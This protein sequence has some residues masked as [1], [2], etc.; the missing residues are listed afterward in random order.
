VQ[1]VSHLGFAAGVGKIV[2]GAMLAASAVATSVPTD[3]G[4]A[5]SAQPATWPIAPA[6]V[7]RP[8]DAPAST[9]G[10]GHRGVDLAAGVGQPVVSSMA[11]IVTV[12]GKVAGRPVVVVKHEGGIRTT[13]LP[14]NP[15]VTVGEHVG[16]GQ[17]IG[18]VAPDSHCISVSCLHWGARE[19]DTYFDP[20]TLLDAGPI[21]LLPLA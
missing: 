11:G 21:V 9:Y 4:S 2:A 16:S 19:G 1:V 10:P 7:I 12:A 5:H 6:V 18:R 3:A 13:Y 8:F 17:V 14:V 20:R 15:E